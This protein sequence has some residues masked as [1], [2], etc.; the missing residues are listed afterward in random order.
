MAT[1]RLSEITV[2]R[3]PAAWGRLRRLTAPLAGQARGFELKKLTLTVP[4]GKTLVLLGPSGCGKSTLLRIIAGLEQP[5]SGRVLYNGKD[6]AGISPGRRHIGYL[7]QSYALYPHLTSRDNITSYFYFRRKTPELNRQREAMF[8]R[9]SQLLDVDISYLLDRRPPRLSGGEKQ[10]VALGRCITREPELFL[11]DEPFSNLDAKLRARYRMHLKTLLREFSIT[12]VYVTHD[13]QEAVLLGDL[14]A[15]MRME[16][17]QERNEGTL[18]Q[19]GTVRELY[20]HPAN[21]FVADFFNLQT[22]VPAIGFLDGASVAPGLAGC[23]VGVRPEDVLIGAG[24][25]AP[26]LSAVVVEVSDDPL[27]QSRV[28]TLQI[29]R[30]RLVAKVPAATPAAVGE[31]VSLHLRHYH[32]FD[33]AGGAAIHPGA[34]ARAALG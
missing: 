19:I 5:D 13:Q 3:R 15:V 24:E 28:L 11:L 7:F 31:R 23:V 22:D 6:V 1:I 30:E 33:P 16:A 2:T 4:H 20:E 34:E 10:R 9:T 14:I 26:S 32:L 21:M 12:T 18:E 25:G 8:R 29:G 17:R 27:K